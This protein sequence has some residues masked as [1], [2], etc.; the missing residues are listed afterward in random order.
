MQRVRLHAGACM[1]EMKLHAGKVRV[2]ASSM[3][4]HACRLMSR[5]EALI[6]LR[7]EQGQGQH[8]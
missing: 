6:T 5:N 2:S 3:R 1:Q 8:Q 4:L 7:M